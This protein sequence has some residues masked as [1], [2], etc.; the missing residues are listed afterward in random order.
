[1]PHV[2]DVVLNDL[3]DGTLDPGVLDGVQRHLLAC[4]ACRARS[5]GQLDLRRRLGGLPRSV[6]PQSPLWRG[7]RARIEAERPVVAIDQAPVVARRPPRWLLLAAAAVTLVVASS[8]ATLLLVDGGPGRART[9]IGAFAPLPASADPAA[10]FAEAEA[11]Y[12]AAATEL[13]A[14]VERERRNLPPDV[15]ERAERALAL[16]D[17]AV[18]ETRA[19]LA[20]DPHNRALAQ[21]ALTAHERRLEFL[22]RIAR[23]STES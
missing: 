20:S 22:Q 14:V 18:W 2:S 19:A 10:R 16:I 7:I 21:M 5:D 9:G 12:L 1:M 8:A 11:A 3:H 4:R 15:A 23:W 6:E 13:M 17:Q